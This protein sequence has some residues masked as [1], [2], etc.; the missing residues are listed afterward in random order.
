MQDLHDI[1]FHQ[2]VN[3]IISVTGDDEAITTDSIALCFI[4]FAAAEIISQIK[5]SE[6]DTGVSQMKGNYTERWIFL[7]PNAE[8][9]FSDVNRRHI[10]NVVG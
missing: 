2:N 7:P 1:L 8:A 6:K 3:A 10:R 5:V 9:D 4:H